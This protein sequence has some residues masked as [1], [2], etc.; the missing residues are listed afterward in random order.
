MI[1]APGFGI[2]LVKVAGSQAVTGAG[3]STTTSAAQFSLPFKAGSETA[4][5]SMTSSNSQVL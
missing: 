2:H 5:V 3:G 4:K 1:Q